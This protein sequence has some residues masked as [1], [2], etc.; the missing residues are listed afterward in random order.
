ML[1]K[2]SYFMHEAEHKAPEIVLF[3][4]LSSVPIFYAIIDNDLFEISIKY[5]PAQ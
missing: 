3:K 2:P 1:M 5:V 4:V